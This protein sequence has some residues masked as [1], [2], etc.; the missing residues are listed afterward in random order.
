MGGDCVYATSECSSSGDIKEYIYF[1]INETV[2]YIFKDDYYVDSKLKIRWTEPTNDT[3]YVIYFGTPFLEL[4]EI[5]LDSPR[6]RIAISY[7]KS[8]NS[9]T[10]WKTVY[11]VLGSVIGFSILF[12]GAYFYWHRIPPQTRFDVDEQTTSLLHNFHEHSQPTQSTVPPATGTTTNATSQTTGS[13]S[14]SREPQ[15]TSELRQRRLQFLNNAQT[16]QNNQQ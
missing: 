8:S 3:N 1:T 10:K 5:Q 7:T 14:G 11:I 6:N 9:S 13:N 2:F 16:Q 4:V 12:F 15:T